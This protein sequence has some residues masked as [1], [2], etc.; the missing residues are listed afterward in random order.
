V[1]NYV[2]IVEPQLNP[3]VEEQAIA[4]ALRMGQGRSV[5]VIRYAV[6]NSIEQVR[7]THA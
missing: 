3:A 7:R 2:H 1:A 6:K 5:T 4:R